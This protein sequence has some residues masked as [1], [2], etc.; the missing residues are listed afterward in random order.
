MDTGRSNTLE[1]VEAGIDLI[2]RPAR[3]QDHLIPFRII[4]P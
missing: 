1:L 3:V 2:G 4:P